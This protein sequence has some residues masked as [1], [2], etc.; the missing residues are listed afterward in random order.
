MAFNTWYF[1]KL[2]MNTWIIHVC[3]FL[4]PFRN[5]KYFPSDTLIL[6][7]LEKKTNFGQP[8]YIMW[9]IVLHVFKYAHMY[10]AQL[11][12]SIFPS[13][14]IICD[15]KVGWTN[16]T[17]FF[18]IYLFPDT[19]LWARGYSR[20]RKMSNYKGIQNTTRKINDCS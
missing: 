9:K 17:N 15:E 20:R 13:L 2:E 19:I 5:C 1:L 3:S 16:T 8:H 12:K 4:K 14:S 11:I 6:W 18:S 10:A 7:T